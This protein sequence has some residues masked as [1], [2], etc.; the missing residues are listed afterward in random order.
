ME[1][2]MLNLPNQLI[3]FKSFCQ[4][5][6]KIRDF[7]GVVILICSLLKARFTNSLH[8]MEKNCPGKSLSMLLPWSGKSLKIAILHLFFSI[9]TPTIP[10][11][12]SWLKNKWSYS[13]RR[14]K[15]IFRDFHSMLRTKL[16]LKVCLNRIF[17]IRKN[18]QVEGRDKLVRNFLSRMK[19]QFELPMEILWEAVVMA[20][21]VENWMV[22]SII[23][24]FMKEGR[25]LVNSDRNFR[26]T[27]W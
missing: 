23:V 13:S 8:T 5:F 7:S 6:P 19:G 2:K 22:K 15:N 12:S 27:T 20:I 18:H 4:L 26:N 1:Q 3:D 14:M 21:E 24:G 9:Y 11:M 16:N 25:S 17:K 10:G